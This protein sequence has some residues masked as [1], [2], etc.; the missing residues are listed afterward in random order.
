MRDETITI[1]GFVSTIACFVLFGFSTND[2]MIYTGKIRLNFTMHLS[3]ML[4]CFQNNIK[5]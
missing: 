3:I 5:S 2:L 4:S 1:L